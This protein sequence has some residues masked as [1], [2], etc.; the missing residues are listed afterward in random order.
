MD[1]RIGQTDRQS[2]PCDQ[3]HPSGKITG[4]QG[5]L[6]LTGYRE[7]QPIRDSDPRRDAVRINE[8]K[9]PRRST[10]DLFQEMNHPAG[11]YIYQNQR[12]H[13]EGDLLTLQGP[14]DLRTFTQGE[15]SSAVDDYHRMAR[16]AAGHGLDPMSVRITWYAGD[17]K[18]EDQAPSVLSTVIRIQGGAIEVYRQMAP[19]W[20][21]LMGKH[22]VRE[23]AGPRGLRLSY[24]GSPSVWMQI[25]N[26]EHSSGV[27]QW[28]I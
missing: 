15:L 8:K 4:N 7:K 27:Y 18:A 26:P 17:V 21:R 6:A 24:E 12:D 11:C 23:V 1:D 13:A 16:W 10:R 5:P 20:H 9:R 28:G 2:V 19:S 25:N 22:V 14:E 3:G